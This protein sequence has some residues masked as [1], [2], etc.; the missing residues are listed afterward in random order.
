MTAELHFNRFDEWPEARE[1]LPA[2]EQA[3]R[4]ALASRP[5]DGTS[6][7]S[8]AGAGGTPAEV[9]FTCLTAEEISE[10]N[11]RYLGRDRP[12]DV[13]AFP[14][15]GPDGRLLGDVYLCPEAAR[16]AAEER[17]LPASEEVVRL[18]VHGTLHV[19]GHEHPEGE[20]RQDAEMYRLQEEILD[21]VLGREG[22]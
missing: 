13:I 8:A 20:G 1:A 21:R 5:A 16:E 2:A 14:L 4:E 19:L 15:D 18:V 9:S 11:R 10:M 12:T 3:A 17:G 7:P 22:R 6:H